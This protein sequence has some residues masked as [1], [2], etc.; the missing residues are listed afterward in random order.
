MQIALFVSPLLV[1][2]SYG[3]GPKPMDLVFANGLVVTVMLATFIAV[4]VTADGRSDWLKGLQL[5]AVYVILGILYFF[6][7]SRGA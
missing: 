7:P 4:P 2:A 6:V 1:F 5:L 3:F